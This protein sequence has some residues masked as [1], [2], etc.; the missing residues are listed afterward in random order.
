MQF[1]DYIIQGLK[2]K[3]TNKLSYKYMFFEPLLS[4]DKS[5]GETTM[6]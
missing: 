6:G 4:Q 3:L 1:K 5:I 2:F